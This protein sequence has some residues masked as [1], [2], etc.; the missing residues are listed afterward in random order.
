MELADKARGIR[1]I[2]AA[3]HAADEDVVVF[4]DELNDLSMFIPEWT[5]IAMGNGREEL[6]AKADFVTKDADQG[7][8]R[9]ALKH[10]GWI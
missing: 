2:M 9:Y 8:I 1:R 5:C 10:F 3:Y 7:G 4:G 6:K